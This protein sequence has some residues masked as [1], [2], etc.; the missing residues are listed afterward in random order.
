MMK[1]LTSF[2]L[3]VAVIAASGFAQVGIFEKAADWTLTTE[4]NLKSPGT[5]SFSNGKYTLEGNGDDIWNTADEGYYIYTEKSGSFSIT[6]LLYWVD[7]GTDPWSKMITMIRQTGSDP[8]S[9]YFGSQLRGNLFGDMVHATMRLAT[10]GG[11]FSYQFYYPKIDPSDP[12]ETLLPVM[13]LAD[14]IWVRTSRVA[15]MNLFLSEWSEDGKTWHLGRV[16]TIE[17]ADPVSV[18]LAITNHLNDQNVA[19]GEFKNV[20]IT[21]LPSLPLSGS[22]TF[23]TGSFQPGSSVEV[24]LTLLNPNKAASTVKIEDIVPAGWTLS[25]LSNGG[26]VSGTKAAWNIQIP[27]GY[28]TIKYTAKAP[29]APEWINTWGGTVGSF[30]I[31][32]TTALTMAQEKPAGDQLFG[33]HADIFKSLD[34]L[35][36]T[37]PVAGGAEYDPA[38]KIYTVW[39]SG[40]DIWDN[41][42]AFHFLY[43]SVSGDFKISAKIHH[44]ESS[45]STGTDVWIKGM[46]MARQNLTPGSPNFANRVRR[47]GQYSWQMRQTQDGGSSSDGNNRVTF[48]TMG[49]DKAD[50]P[51]VMVE[52]IGNQWKIYYKDEKGAGNWMQV[53]S[54]QT[55][56]LEDPILVGLAVTAHQLGMVQY[57]WFKDVELELAEPPA[58]MEWSLF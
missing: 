8:A 47:D 10:G 32:G 49:Y 55:L 39:G 33:Y 53:Q 29:S 23:S 5:A 24:T 1:K 54:T 16:E 20:S 21:D 2:L 17:M 18:G 22:R 6:A 43:T 37:E 14:G 51:R 40:W 13:S 46:L 34:R 41:D 9:K 27:F 56:Q 19:I 58:V 31:T 26:T 42:D 44:D 28:T 3:F 45:R 4:G 48:T 35:G 57:T 11:S 36:G 7:P 52:R 12:N 38:T 25:N 30:A 50:F 15:E